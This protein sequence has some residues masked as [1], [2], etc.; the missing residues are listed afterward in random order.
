M[1]VANKIALLVL[2]P[3][4]IYAF[5]GSLRLGMSNYRHYSD[6]LSY[7]FTESLCGYGL[8]AMKYYPYAVETGNTSDVT[9]VEVFKITDTLIEQEIHELEI[10]VG[11]VY[12]E[13][14][15]RNEQTGIYLFEKPGSEPLVNGGDWVK[16]FGS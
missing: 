16:F 12:R 2:N 7:L 1:G 11:Y 13:V 9:V 5:Y 4:S 10:G 15:I 8:Y 3:Q 14:M 6:G